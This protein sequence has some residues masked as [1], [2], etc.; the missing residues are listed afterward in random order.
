VGRNIF[1]ESCPHCSRERRETDL[2][3]QQARP[4]TDSGQPIDLPF[5]RPSTIPPSLQQHGGEMNPNLASRDETATAPPRAVGTEGIINLIT[6]DDKRNGESM[7][8]ATTGSVD[9]QFGSEG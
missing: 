7:P 1:Q 3:C 4:A 8:G 2:C 9:A 5:A 6:R